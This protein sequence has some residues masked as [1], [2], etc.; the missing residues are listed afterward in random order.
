MEVAKKFLGESGVECNHLARCCLFL[1]TFLTLVWLQIWWFN[2]LKGLHGYTFYRSGARVENSLQ[3][4][5]WTWI[6]GVTAPDKH[7][8]LSVFLLLP[9]EVLYWS[10][11]IMWY[12]HCDLLF[13]VIFL[14][15]LTRAFTTLNLVSHYLAIEIRVNEPPARHEIHILT[16]CVCR[17]TK[18]NKTLKR[19]KRWNEKKEEI[20][21]VDKSCVNFFSLKNKN[22]CGVCPALQKSLIDILTLGQ[23]NALPFWE[24]TECLQELSPCWWQNHFIHFRS[25]P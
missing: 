16:F 24:C 9:S 7:Q 11:Y 22:K 21:G 14:I 10:H 23:L 13:L 8:C 20:E 4:E 25:C 17:K 2:L 5:W 18:Q 12:I 1:L 6:W 15:F 19:E 3:Q